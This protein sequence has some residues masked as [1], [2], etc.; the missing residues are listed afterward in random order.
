MT[1]VIALNP[2]SVPPPPIAERRTRLGSLAGKTIGF[3]S[4]NKP[5]ADVVLQRVARL[6]H[7]HFGITAKHYTKRIPSLEAPRELLVEVGKDC[8]GVVLAAYD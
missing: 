3:L 4:N 1:T 2:V 8:Q 5:N 7:A 6:L